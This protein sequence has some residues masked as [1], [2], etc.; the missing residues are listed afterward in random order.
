MVGDKFERTRPTLALC[1]PVNNGSSSYNG[2]PLL[3]PSPQPMLASLLPHLQ[4]FGP[5]PLPDCARLLAAWQPRTVRADEFLAS[6]GQIAQELFFVQRGVLRIVSQLPN[7][8][9]VT[10]GFFQESQFCALLH[11]FVH[12]V[13]AVASIQAGCAA[14]VLAIRKAGLDELCQQLPYLPG[15]LGQM[16]Q[17][18]LWEKV[19]LRNSYLGRDAR[20]CYQQFLRQQ[21]DVAR[22]VPLATIASYLGITPQSLSRLRKTTG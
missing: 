19:Q 11:S 4:R 18:G 20:A 16:T 9:E 22:R 8:K 12:Q 14:Q 6:A 2:C 15:L 21:P 13:P 10:H 3:Q 1:R 17:Q 7:G 5:V